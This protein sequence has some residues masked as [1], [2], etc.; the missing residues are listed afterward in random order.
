MDSFNT[1]QSVNQEQQADQL[2]F[3][4]GDREYDVDAAAKKIS[5]ADEHISRLEQENAEFRKKLE[6]ALT[7]DQLEAKLQE[8]LQKLNK[9]S[10]PESRSNEATTSFDPEKLSQ[11]AREAA[12][13]AIEEREKERLQKEQQATAEATFRQT[14]D[15]LASVYGKE[16]IT[17]ALEE[18]GIEVDVADRMARDPVQAKVL[19]KALR[20][21]KAKPSAAPLGSVNTAAFGVRKDQQPFSDK[22]TLSTDDIIEALRAARG[23]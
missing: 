7:E 1:D 12:L 2:T 10:S 6:S 21:D 9:A 15:T 14:F 17:S 5:S 23:N 19:L 22:Q 11:T 4:V 3:K 20:V 13:S 18:A 16:G 8:A